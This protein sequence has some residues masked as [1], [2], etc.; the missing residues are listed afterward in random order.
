MIRSIEKSV[1]SPGNKPATFRLVSW[2]RNQLRYLVP[3]QGD[4]V[5]RKKQQRPMKVENGSYL[6]NLPTWSWSN[7]TAYPRLPLKKADVIKTC[8]VLF[9]LK[10]GDYMISEAMVP[11]YQ[12]IRRHMPENRDDGPHNHENPSSYKSVKRVYLVIPD[13]GRGCSWFVCK[14]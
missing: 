11:I 6:P 5:E 12:T 10:D 9:C 4:N 3:P 1:T 7:S 2:C 13:S 14:H 8:V